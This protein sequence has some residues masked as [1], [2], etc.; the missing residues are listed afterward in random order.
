MDPSVY[1][2]EIGNDSSL[3]RVKFDVIIVELGGRLGGSLNA[4]DAPAQCDLPRHQASHHPGSDVYTFL[5]TPLVHGPLPGLTLHQQLD[6]ESSQ[7]TSGVE[8]G[9]RTPY[10]AKSPTPLCQLQHHP[11]ATTKR[12][13]RRTDAVLGTQSHKSTVTA[14]PHVGA[15]MC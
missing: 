4:R 13:R 1:F 12:S 8:A 10:I 15:T 9:P 3:A 7:T 11:R 2:S 5:L 14:S 6:R